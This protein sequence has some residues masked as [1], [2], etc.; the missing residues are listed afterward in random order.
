MVLLFCEVSGI[1]VQ[2]AG[3]KQG[4]GLR[5][6]RDYVVMGTRGLTDVS[7]VWS[8]PPIMVNTLGPHVFLGRYV[9][10]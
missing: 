9:L 1:S 7:G 5:P 3:R 6:F 10:R 4:F 2:G 8:V